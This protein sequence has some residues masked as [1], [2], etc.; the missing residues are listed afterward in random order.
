MAHGRCTSAPR[1]AVAAIVGLVLLATG[2]IVADDDASD[3]D[4]LNSW[5]T[6]SFSSAVQATEDPDF[7]DVSLHMA[8]IWTDRDDGH[9]LYVEQAMR[10]YPDQ[11]YRQRVYRLRELA[12]GLFECQVY[13]LPDPTAVVGAWRD[14]HPLAELRPDDLEVREG[15]AILMRRRDDTFVGSTLATL[16]DSSLR[17]A[18][19]AT[20]EVVVTPD[21]IVS[22]DRGFAAD[23]T[24]VWG[25]T[26]GG[27]VFDRIVDDAG[28]GTES[29]AEPE[30]APVS[31]P[32]PVTEPDPDPGPESEAEG[33][34]GVTP[35]AESPPP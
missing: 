30:S 25:A 23:G 26:R 14:E 27:Y 5:M 8:T 16:C 28:S 35:A 6:G 20:S 12:P 19:Y 2:S 11:P 31:D 4:L 34:D 10:D 3:L 1:L 17:G 21:G 13:T 22:W 24:Q 29:A 15:C 18:S 33:R 7:F 32:D 9:W